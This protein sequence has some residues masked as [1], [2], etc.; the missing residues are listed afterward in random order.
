MDERLAFVTYCGL[1]CNLCADRGR[2]PRQAAALQETMA[3]EGWPHWGPSI[4]GFTQFWAFL[5]KLQTE[6]GCPG[7]RAGGGYPECDIRACA[8]ERNL[9]LCSQCAGFPCE[10][11]EA[12]GE[13]YP[14]LIADNRRMQRVGLERWLAEQEERVR[15]GVIYADFRYS[16]PETG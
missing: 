6:G 1:Y 3:E 12:L 4:S 7:C 16:V 5:E 8:R 9:D 15:R 11:I 14:T 10:R 13:R 2:I